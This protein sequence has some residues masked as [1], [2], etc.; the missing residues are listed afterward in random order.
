MPTVQPLFDY[1]QKVR[2]LTGSRAGQTAWIASWPYGQGSYSYD[3]VFFDPSAALIPAKEDRTP[4]LGY[5]EWE[6]EINRD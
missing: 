2:I 4:P 3:V 5:A 1:G 6:L